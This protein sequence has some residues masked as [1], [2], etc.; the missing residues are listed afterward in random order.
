LFLFPSV[1]C[2]VLYT[3][4][5]LGAGYVTTVSFIRNYICIR[6]FLFET[7]A[8]YD[9]VVGNEP[10]RESRTVSNV[11]GLLSFSYILHASVFPVFRKS[12]TVYSG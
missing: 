9:L 11:K 3:V 6:H 8:T 2:G 4:L 12:C 5:Y 1:W 7:T 10:R